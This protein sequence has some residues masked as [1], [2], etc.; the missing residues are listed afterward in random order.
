[1]TVCWDLAGQAGGVRQKQ[2]VS[3]LCTSMRRRQRQTDYL[4]AAGMAGPRRQSPIAAHKLCQTTSNG[5]SRR[6]EQHT[7]RCLALW[8]W[9][10]DVASSKSM[11]SQWFQASKK[12]WGFKPHCGHSLQPKPAQPLCLQ[13][14]TDS[15]YLPG[16]PSG[17]VLL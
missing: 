5:S 1:M 4:C 8:S 9:N 15:G 7:Q 6:P 16:G 12:Q 2:S 11:H 13:L 17:R 14:L 10:A 3:I